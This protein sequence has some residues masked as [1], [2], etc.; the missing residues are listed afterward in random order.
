MESSVQEEQQS[1]NGDDYREDLYAELH[2]IERQMLS[3]GGSRTR[4]LQREC[5]AAIRCS[6][7]LGIRFKYLI[8]HTKER[9]NHSTRL[10]LQ[11]NCIPEHIGVAAQLNH[12]VIW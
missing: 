5:E 3:D 6:K 1:P 2:S 4:R 9:L 8:Q 11:G 7:L 10:P 12:H